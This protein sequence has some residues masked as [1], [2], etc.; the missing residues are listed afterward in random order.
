MKKVLLKVKRYDGEEYKMDLED[1]LD[2]QCEVI[3]LLDITSEV[4]LE[5]DSISM[6]E[7]REKLKEEYRKN[8]EIILN[9]L[10]VILNVQEAQFIEEEQDDVEL[11]LSRKHELLTI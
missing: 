1:L 2:I 8:K 7:K 5:S 6:E 11:I 10:K 4:F 9:D 3:D